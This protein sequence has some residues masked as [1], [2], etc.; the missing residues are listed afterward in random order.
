MPQWNATLGVSFMM[1]FNL[2]VLGLLL[3]YVGII[4]VVG[5]GEPIPKMTVLYILS[6]F[7]GL[8]Y[9]LFMHTD[10]YKSITKELKKESTKKRRKNTILLWLYTILSFLL[11]VLLAFLIRDKYF[12]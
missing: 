6:G 10:K 5:G 8:N 3:Q 1:F 9:F 11:P 4:V 12:S 2:F 7:Y